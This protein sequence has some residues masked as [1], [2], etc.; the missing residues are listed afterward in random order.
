VSYL[1]Q[2]QRAIDFIEANLDDDVPLAAVAR[3]ARVSAWHFQRIFKGLTGDTLKSYIRARRLSRALDALLRPDARIID[4]ALDAGFESQAAFTRAFRAAFDTTPA[5][6]RAAKRR[7]AHV[8]KLRIDRR[9]IEHVRAHVTPEPQLRRLPAMRVVGMRTTFYG[10]D[11][12]RCNLGQKLPPLWD[13]FLARIEDI[14]P[15]DRGLACGVVRPSP[16]LEELDYVAGVVVPSSRVPRGMTEIV[17]PAA[18]YAIF[19]H[20]GFPKDLHLT[21]NYVYASW[22]LRSKLR[23]TYGPDLELFGPDY[24]ADSAGSVIRYAIPVRRSGRETWQAQCRP[25]AGRTR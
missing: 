17:V 6:Y 4:I 14:A 11:S 9:Y 2:V 18:T 3:H 16:G 24:V 15:H 10:V 1:V 20:R 19:E 7:F 13:A 8:R 23:H 22:L 12:D 5:R 25:S 21:V